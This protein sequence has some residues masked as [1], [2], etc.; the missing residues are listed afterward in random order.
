[1]AFCRWARLW[2]LQGGLQFGVAPGGNLGRAVGILS[3][4]SSQGAADLTAYAGPVFTPDLGVGVLAYVGIGLPGVT[5]GLQGQIDLLDVSL[6]TAVVAA[7]SHVSLPDPRPV[8]GT[9]Y[10]GTAIPGMEP[11]SISGSRATTGGRACS[12]AS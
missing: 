12:S 3:G 9:D 5:V 11:S 6:P 7:A 2:D 8:T 1:M 10:A 4:D